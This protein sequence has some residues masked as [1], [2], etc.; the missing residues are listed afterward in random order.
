M[1]TGSKELFQRVDDDDWCV[2]GTTVSV[3]LQRVD[4]PMWS[5]QTKIIRLVGSNGFTCSFSQ[6]LVWQLL[7]H[8][9]KSLL[10][11]VFLDIIFF[12][13]NLI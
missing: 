1:I 3:S 13:A 6:G 11:M 4:G 7:I 5:D 2:S 9:E 8:Q 12:E 10:Y